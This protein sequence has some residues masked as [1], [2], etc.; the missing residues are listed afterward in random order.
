[1]RIL[2]AYKTTMNE[3]LCV[4]IWKENRELRTA[5]GKEKQKHQES[6]KE[7]SIE[8]IFTSEEAQAFI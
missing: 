2:K 8:Y 4:L 3:L 5:H 1:M 6:K 7:I